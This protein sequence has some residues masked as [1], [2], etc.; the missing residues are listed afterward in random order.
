MSSIFADST[1]IPPGSSD[2]NTDL[3]ASF[4]IYE[5]YQRALADEEVSLRALLTS[6]RRAFS[7]KHPDISSSSSDSFSHGARHTF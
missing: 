3:D 1:L 4:D 2:P 6:T 5:V 7:V